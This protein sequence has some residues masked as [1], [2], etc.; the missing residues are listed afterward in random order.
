[1]D[2]YVTLFK[3]TSFIPCACLDLTDLDLD[4]KDKQFRISNS[5]QNLMF[6]VSFLNQTSLAHI[7]CFFNFLIF[8]VPY[9][10]FTFEINNNIYLLCIYIYIFFNM[11]WCLPAPLIHQKAAAG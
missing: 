5:I 3:I 4:S 8:K 7:L 11:S 2:Q 6:G 1:M 9:T 10:L